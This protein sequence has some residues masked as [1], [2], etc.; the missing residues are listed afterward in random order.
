MNEM[1]TVTTRSLPVEAFGIA[2]GVVLPR[3]EY[4]SVDG[5]LEDPIAR[6]GRVGCF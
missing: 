1:T 4:L 6:T 3:F 2:D 5:A